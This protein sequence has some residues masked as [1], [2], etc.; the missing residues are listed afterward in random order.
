MPHRLYYAPY[1][2][3]TFSKSSKVC[4]LFKKKKKKSSQPLGGVELVMVFSGVGLIAVTV[5]AH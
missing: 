2:F 5:V 4:E 1:K 3:S